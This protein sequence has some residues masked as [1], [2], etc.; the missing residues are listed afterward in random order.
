MRFQSFALVGST[1][2]AI[3]FGDLVAEA[4][5][6]ADATFIAPLHRD[7]DWSPFLRSGRCGRSASFSVAKAWGGGGGGVVG[8]CLT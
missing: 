1:G 8:Q 2:A 3:V 4:G 5:G 6:V 7:R